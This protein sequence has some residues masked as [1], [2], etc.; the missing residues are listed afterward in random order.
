MHALFRLVIV[1]FVIV[2]VVVEL[3][4]LAGHAVAGRAD[5][6]V[7]EPAI[8]TTDPHIGIHLENYGL[9]YLRV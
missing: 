2:V 1:E 7:D 5:A 3:V 6:V 4:G 9:V 8:S